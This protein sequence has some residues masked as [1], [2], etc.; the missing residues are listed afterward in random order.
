MKLKFRV[1]FRISVLGFIVSYLAACQGSNLGTS[2]E[3]AIA[4]SNPAT[5]EAIAVKSDQPTVTA[6]AIPESPTVKPT[7]SPTN[8]PSLLD[9]ENIASTDD[10]LVNQMIAIALQSLETPKPEKNLLKN[11]LKSLFYIDFTSSQIQVNEF[12][13]LET[14]PAPLR[15]WIKD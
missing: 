11:S 10:R 4:P 3:G 5:S 7:S 15:S 1:I 14:A 6:S 2:L 9:R 8:S 13:D 12:S